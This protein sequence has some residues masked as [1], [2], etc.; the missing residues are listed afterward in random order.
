MKK[1]I[2][3]L[4]F[5]VLVVL[6]DFAFRTLNTDIHRNL[7]LI[8]DYSCLIFLIILVVLMWEMKS[9]I[10]IKNLVVNK[11]KN[12]IFFF[13]AERLIRIVL[14]LLMLNLIVWLLKPL[15]KSSR[16]YS[17]PYSDSKFKSK[18]HS[19]Y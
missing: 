14:F 17:G 7:I 19:K 10:N 6:G 3:V 12:L 9:K 13:T 2:I 11:I 18:F 15:F 16:I 4:F 1:I 8:L 5:F